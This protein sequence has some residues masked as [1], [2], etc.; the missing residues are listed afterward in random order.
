MNRKIWHFLKT[1]DPG[2]Y[3]IINVNKIK[4]KELNMKN[5]LLGLLINT[6]VMY[7]VLPIVIVGSLA[8]LWVP[9]LFEF[10]G[11]VVIGIG[12]TILTLVVTGIVDYKLESVN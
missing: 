3:Y 9:L 5:F 6:L 2:N 7:V 1:F 11:A 4:L 12:I 10:R 8:W